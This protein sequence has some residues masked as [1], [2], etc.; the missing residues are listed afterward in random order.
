MN[1][2]MI[3]FVNY[4]NRLLLALLSG[5]FM[6]FSWPSIGIF[7]LIFIAFV[8]LLILEK[9]SKN[10][11]QVFIYSFLSFFVFN[12]ITTYWVYH[13][14]FFGAIIAF[15]I[16]AVLMSIVF[17]L[18]HKIKLLTSNRIGYFSFIVLWI[19]MEYLHLNWDLSWPWLTLGNVFA[20]VP[21]LVQWYEFTGF[22]GGSFFVILMNLLIFRVYQK[23]N[24]KKFLL[25]PILVFLI[26]VFS[27]AYIYVN[28]KQENNNNLNV[29]IIQP[30]IDPYIDKFSKGYQEQ[31]TDFIA[32]VKTN[33][34]KETQLLLAPETALLEGFW[35]HKIEST[36][37]VRSL[38]DLQN[39]FPNLNI[40][41]GAT[42]YKL[43]NDGEKKT[44]TAREIRNQNVFYD[45]YNSAVFIP[46]DGDIQV[47]HK[48]KLVPGAEKMPFPNILDP[49]A[50]L[51][52]D[53]GGVSGSLGSENSLNS[54]L[55]D[56]SVIS[57]LI[58]YES[59]YG[60][61]GLGITN[62]LAVITNDGWWKN[63]AGY[64]QHFQYA[65]LRAI[66]Q[67]KWVV[68]SANTGISGVINSRGDVLQQSKWDEAI[69]LVT[70]VNLNNISTFYSEFG[71]YIGRVAT[72]ISSMLLIV[73]FV[74]VR[75]R[76]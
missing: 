28:F 32:L 35:E 33:I 10:A 27:S 1:K 64:K 61:M 74:K 36:Y 2:N 22:L 58:C 66:E 9:E 5:L 47:Y 69:C 59:V 6:A 11:K 63:T 14:T 62:L 30:N 39:E 26:S 34:T 40:L 3:I 20:N 23:N 68:R 12:I 7:P 16:N 54:F 21:L 52:V 45:A 4:M 37:S 18:F 67:R 44:I 46:K 15:I 17:L 43:F 8:P 19:S 76:H 57:P 41:I 71:D 50:K 65:R 49:L 48:R 13:A 56:S 42:T 70:K 25:L 75:L 24:A 72:F 29:L 73:V 55:V 53:L 38:R 51:V 31:L 60:E